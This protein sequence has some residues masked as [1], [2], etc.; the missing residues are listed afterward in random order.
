M[1]EVLAI[2]ATGTAAWTTTHALGWWLSTRKA[3]RR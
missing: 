2:A 1:I 3:A